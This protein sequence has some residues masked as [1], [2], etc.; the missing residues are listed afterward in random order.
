MNKREAA[1]CYDAVVTAMCTKM[2]D[3]YGEGDKEKSRLFDGRSSWI[4]S[5]FCCKL[6][7]GPGANFLS[8]EFLLKGLGINNC[9]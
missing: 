4:N 9:N 5:I 7:M 1:L 3:M 2:S 8:S 6:K